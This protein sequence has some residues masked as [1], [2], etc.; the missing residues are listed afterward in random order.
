[1]AEER[2]EGIAK[3]KRV[4]MYS[5]K[6]DEERKTREEK[7]RKMYCRSLIFQERDTRLEDG[8]SV[9]AIK[10]EVLVDETMLI[11]ERFGAVMKCTSNMSFGA[12]N[13]E[14]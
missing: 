1:M 7:T 14:C 10:S 13:R 5:Q 3:M 9:D 6:R 12:S 4:K 11:V 2:S 8:E